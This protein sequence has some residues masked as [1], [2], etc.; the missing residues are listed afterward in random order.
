MQ[1]Q[2]S[3]LYVSNKLGLVWSGLAPDGPHLCLAL[4]QR[5]FMS[6][7]D[8]TATVEALCHHM[9]YRRGQTERGKVVLIRRQSSALGA[10]LWAAPLMNVGFWHYGVT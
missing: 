10:L 5:A 3:L 1:T 7:A 8:S 9:F 2:H 6:V 4:D